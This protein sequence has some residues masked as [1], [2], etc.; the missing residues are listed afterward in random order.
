VERLDAG[1]CPTCGTRDATARRE[2]AI[3]G[4]CQRCQDGIGLNEDSAARLGR[5]RGAALQRPNCV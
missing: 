5:L 4:L 1:S 3:T 2:H